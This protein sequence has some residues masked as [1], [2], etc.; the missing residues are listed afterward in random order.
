MQLTSA[1]VL[2]GVAMA[3]VWLKAP[4]IPALLGALGA[5]LALYWRTQR[6]AN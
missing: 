1:S 2:A 3:L 5:G 6:A 4:I